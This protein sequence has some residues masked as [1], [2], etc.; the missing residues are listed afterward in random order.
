MYLF[1]H[2][3]G[4]LYQIDS[5]NV[6]ATVYNSSWGRSPDASA[7]VIRFGTPTPSVSNNSSKQLIDLTF[8][9][10]RGIQAAAFNLTITAP[11]GMTIR[12]STNGSVPNATTGTV[13][14]TPIAVN[15]NMIFKVFAYDATRESKVTTQTYIINS[16]LTSASYTQQQ[17]NDALKDLPIVCL[18][19]T[20]SDA[21]GTEA[22]CSFEF[23][24]KFG[25]NKSTFVDAGFRIFGNTSKGYPKKN[26]RVYFRS[27]YGYNKLK[28]KVYEKSSYEGYAPTDEFDA[29][30]LKAGT[31]FM[32]PGSQY[33][34]LGGLMMSDY[35]AHELLRRMGN[36]DIHA[37]FVHMFFNGKYYGLYVLRE[38]FNQNY[39]KSYYGGE[40]TEYEVIDG[41]YESS[42]WPVG[43]TAQGTGAQWAETKQVA[44]TNFQ[45]LKKK[46][47]MKQY[48]DMMLEFFFTDMEHEYRAA[49]HKNYQNTKFVIMHNDTDGFL[50][51]TNEGGHN[52]TYKMDR[53]S[54]LG[55]GNIT[56]LAGIQGSAA[57]LEY[58]TM[59][60]DRVQDLYINPN[61]LITTTGLTKLIN[62]S[63]NIVY[64]SA[65]LETTRWN[66][67]TRDAWNNR[68]NA[69]INSFPSRLTTV[70]NFFKSNNWVHTLQAP[71]FSKP[72]GSLSIGE[73]LFITNPNA[74]TQVY[75][76]T[77]GTDVVFDNN[78]SPTAKLYN[79]TTGID[80]PLGKTKIRA[81]AFATGNFGMYADAEYVVSRP[82]KI[83]AIAYQPNP[84]APA[85]EPKGS[86]V[87][88]FFN[89]TNTGTTAIDIS[90]FMVTEAI[91]TFRLPMGTS[92]ASGETIM[93]CSDDT[94]YP[95]V[96][97]RK[98]KFPKGKL[99]NEGENISFR[100]NLGNLVNEVRYDTLAPWPY[101]KGN[102]SYIRLKN[103]SLDNKIGSNWEA[104]SLTPL[105]TT[106]ALNLQNKAIFTASGRQDGQKAIIN[107]VS[108]VNKNVDYYVVEKLEADKPSFERLDIVNAQYSNQDNALQYYTIT[109][110]APKKEVIQYRVGMVV[111]GQT[112]PL[113]GSTNVQY[114]EP[115][116]LDF[117]QFVD[118]AVYPNPAAESITIDLSNVVNK[119][120]TVA[121]TDLMGKII[122]QKQLENAP[123]S[124]N[125]DLNKIPS[126]QYFIHIQTKG[127][128]VVTKSI[129]ITQ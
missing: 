13:Y 97:L 36:K 57:N 114:L 43:I 90:N 73:K 124:I 113:Q 84:I 19:T 66:F 31:D 94:K 129:I 78:I 4:V 117:S 109:D 95:S 11:A 118:Y 77:D 17:L 63:R 55:A 80:L 111:N 2:F 128:K 119:E 89:L 49:A 54:A 75:Y 1:Q 62:D 88:E 29:L 127:K 92:I 15:Q 103:N 71:T 6:G 112:T 39:M 20:A 120:T 98:F 121:I 16:G 24:N 56:T 125:M 28:H 25:E 122:V 33:W 22:G 8:S 64:N 91:D 115:I 41:T 45:E 101:A 3:N 93:L 46:V 9:H 86:D 110:N 21:N 107:W 72:S 42:T 82:I 106:G 27:Q 85:A 48:V 61:G 104:V 14:T 7:S 30:D 18:G 74:N 99:A 76:T 123:N 44:T 59:V 50:T 69:I 96:Q 102:G 12:Y 81:R 105:L 37:R 58:R 116:A 100:D 52:F 47:D 23:I 51:P 34:G 87:Y 65:M 79:A 126:G 5:L 40:D 70:L 26:Y 10:T 83:T 68:V 67:Y 32:P 60:R 35:M 38:R 53:Q 108:N